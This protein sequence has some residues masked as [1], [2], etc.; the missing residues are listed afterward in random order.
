MKMPRDDDDDDDVDAERASYVDAWESLLGLGVVAC[1]RQRGVSQVLLPRSAQLLRCSA[2]AAAAD[3]AG[4]NARRMH[5]C[6]QA[7]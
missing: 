6:V 1:S 7:S 2:A 3:S 5:C 4:L